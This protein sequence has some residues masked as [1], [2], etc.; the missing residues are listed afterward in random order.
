[1]SSENLYTRTPNTIV[2]YNKTWCPDCHRARAVLVENQVQFLDVD[3][4]KD[5]KAK[6]FVK[7]INNGNESV[8]TIVFPDGTALVEPR[9]SILAEKLKSL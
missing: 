1:M 6:E 9:K 3:V 8:P 4:S 2:F 7:Q 5:N